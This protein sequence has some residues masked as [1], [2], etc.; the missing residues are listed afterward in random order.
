MAYLNSVSSNDNAKYYDNILK[1]TTLDNTIVEKF[2]KDVHFCN[3]H[4]TIAGLYLMTRNEIEARID[5]YK[6][7]F[8]DIGYMYI[9]LGHVSALA[10]IPNTG[11]FFFRKDGGSN[12]LERAQHA[13]E[14]ENDNYQPSMFPI[15][16]NVS[17]KSD[18]KRNVGLEYNTQYTFDCVMSILNPSFD[19]DTSL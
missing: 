19:P 6:Q 18:E 7:K 14:Y 17:P 2:Y 10:Y 5:S 9:G 1:D 11:N 12:S 15:F 3:Q 4:K 16:S 13:T 8:I